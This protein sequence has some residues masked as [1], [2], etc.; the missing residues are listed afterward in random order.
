QTTPAKHSRFWALDG[1]VI[2]QFGS[3]AFRVH[4]SRLSTQSVWFE[5]LFER[6]AGRE[7]PL[8]ADEENIKDIVVENLDGCDA[9]D[10][11]AL[12]AMSDFEAL[13]TAMEDS[14]DFVYSRPAVLTS[15]AIFRAATVLKFPKFLTFAK[16]HLLEEFHP[17]LANFNS[18][19][20]AQNPVAAVVLGRNWDFPRI[21]K[22]AFYE[23]ARAEPEPFPTDNEGGLAEAP[24][25]L[26]GLEMDDI[27]LLNNAQKRLAMAWLAVFP[28]TAGEACPERKPC[29]SASQRLSTW[30][31]VARTDQ[32]LQKFHRDP[33]GGLAALSAMRWKTTHSF[34]D[35]CYSAQRKSLAKMQGQIWDDL[36]HWLNIPVDHVDEE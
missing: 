12:V 18:R 34:C 1:N 36:D 20:V 9:Y 13:L 30:S 29:T 5:K 3:M 8:E 25:P 28:S 6:R 7:E 31:I 4:R 33:I 15:M 27:I 22:R 23:L 10:L 24:S 17:D 32:V 14:I 21:L 26:K 35:K 2:L 11:D 19:H 16:T